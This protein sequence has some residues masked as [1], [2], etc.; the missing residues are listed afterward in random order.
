MPVPSNVQ[1][2]IIS[3]KQ[4]LKGKQL[5]LFLDYDGT[6]AEIQSEPDNT[7]MSKDMKRVLTDVSCLED[8]IVVPISGR[9]TED[10]RDRI[11][12]KDIVYSGNHGLEMSGLDRPQQSGGKPG[13][14]EYNLNEEELSKLRGGI[15]SIVTEMKEKKLGK[16]VGGNIEDKDTAMTWHFFN[17][18]PND[19]EQTV[20]R[21]CSIVKKNGLPVFDGEGCIE[22]RHPKITKGYAM[23]KILREKLGENWHE[24]HSAIFIGDSST[25]EEGFATL[26]EDSG[27]RSDCVTFIKIQTDNSKPTRGKHIF[28]GPDDVYTLLCELNNYYLHSAIV[29]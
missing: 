18:P 10:L 2:A 17:V 14:M 25:D 21:A 11:G 24:T 27:F 5:V 6:L 4:S 16:E 19:V 15:K 13:K 9:K 12:I 8:V 23:K 26:L 29:N 1:S 20:Q 28:S 3:I 7:Y 22:V